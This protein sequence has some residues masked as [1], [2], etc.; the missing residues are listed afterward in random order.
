M[1]SVYKV[2]L[3]FNGIQSFKDANTARKFMFNVSH[4]KKKDKSSV[5]TTLDVKENFG[6]ML[7]SPKLSV[8]ALKNS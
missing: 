2:L 3:Q 8:S 4:S 7:K 5:A 1:I 6:W